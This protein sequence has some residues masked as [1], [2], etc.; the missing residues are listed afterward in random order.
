[1]SRKDT[2]THDGDQLL[3]APDEP[4]G[5]PWEGVSPRVLTRAF[6]KFSLGALPAGGLHGV[7]KSAQFESKLQ[8]NLELFLKEV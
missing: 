4:T 2:P 5:L 6:K 3:L 8:R 7:P 1:M